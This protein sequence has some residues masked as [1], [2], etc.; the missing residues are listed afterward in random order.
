[1]RL[2]FIKILL[3]LCVAPGVQL[4]AAPMDSMA[5]QQLME[6]AAAAGEKD[7]AKG[8][9]LFA[10]AKG[11]AKK[12]NFKCLLADALFMEASLYFNNLKYD[13]AIVNLK[14]AAAL[15]RGLEKTF[16]E[17]RC[18]ELQGVVYQYTGD[19]A[20]SLKILFQGLPKA[21]IS[22]DSGVI[23][24]FYI[25]IGLAYKELNDLDN[26]LKYFHKSGK[27]EEGLKDATSLGIVYHNMADVYNRK[28]EFVNAVRYY[29]QAMTMLLKTG[30]EALAATSASDLGSVYFSMQ[31]PDSA[32]F[33]K[34]SAVAELAAQGPQYLSDY[35]YAITSLGFILASE[36][37]LNK[38]KIYLSQC[39]ECQLLLEDMMYAKSYYKFHYEYYKRIGQSDSAVVYLERLLGVKD[40][41]AAAAANFENQ[42]IAIR[43]EFDQK[44]SEDF[45]KYQLQLSRQ[46]TEATAYKSRMYLS[47]AIGALLLAFTGYFTNRLR[48]TQRAKR[49]RELEQMRHDIASDLHDDVGST[50]SSIQIMSSVAMQE[51]GGN[52]KAQASI[53]AITDLSEKVALG[54]REI[55][56]SVN[57]SNDDLSALASRLRHM[58]TEALD[59]AGITFLFMKDL[60]QPDLK[61]L[62]H[63]RKDLIMIY[64]EALN[65]ICKYSESAQVDIRLTQKKHQLCLQLKDYGRG[66]DVAATHH[67]NT[68]QGNGL[69]NMKRR[70]AA[71]HADID[72]QSEIG[73]GTGILLNVPLS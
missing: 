25:N 30:N 67:E 37:Q 45:L 7:E 48:I 34:Q 2:K 18:Y 1:M 24:S 32:I 12:N 51:A 44:A 36:N 3:L 11:A 42:R 19:Y 8:H 65:N 20:A 6:Q 55:V 47:I 52:P 66:F 71:M 16:K 49:R 40:S 27:L 4:T 28:N 23:S 29:K 39:Q 62:P 69:E 68:L 13:T 17:A 31:Q 5:I 22:G 61:L 56:W 10:T 41:L 63:V 50:L 38:A 46:Q 64:K 53:G 70:A 15:Y 21:R 58:A 73:K 26:A 72:I 54:I 60:E 43:Y 33:Y 35:C 14:S 59:C 57:P 9:Q